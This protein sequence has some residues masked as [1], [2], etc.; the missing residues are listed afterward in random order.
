[1]ERYNILILA[2]SRMKTL[3]THLDFILQRENLPFDI[4]IKVICGGGLEEIRKLGLQI[5]KDEA[6]HLVIVWA[7]IN[8]LTT[9]EKPTRKVSPKYDDI[10]HMV[11]AITD[12][13]HDVKGSLLACTQYL[14]IGQITGIDLNSYNKG[15]TEYD[16][17]QKLINSGVREINRVV[18]S[19]NEENGMIPPWVFSD[20]HVYDKREEVHLDKYVKYE[21]GLHPDNLLLMKW[22]EAT[23]KS[24]KINLRNCFSY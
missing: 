15:R 7:G 18:C 20:I 2:D 4:N 14:V 24:I 21:D 5:L 16:T 22:A 1:M 9:L 17:L 6:Y 11:D 8:D 23:I 12:K 13:L 3:G 19:I 10:W